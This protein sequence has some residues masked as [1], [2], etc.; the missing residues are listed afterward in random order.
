VVMKVRIIGAGLSGLAAAYYLR[1]SAPN[2][3]IEIIEQNSL[4][5]GR[6]QTFEYARGLVEFGAFMVMPWYKNYRALISDLGISADL[7]NYT[8]FK[9]VYARSQQSDLISTIKFATSLLPS[10][11]SNGLNN[12]SPNPKVWKYRT[13]AEYYQHASAETI[14]GSVNDAVTAYTYPNLNQFAASLYFPFAFNMESTNS[15]NRLARLKSG[16]NFLI[17]TLH[18]YLLENNVAFKFNQ[19]WDGQINNDEKTIVAANLDNS[20]WQSLLGISIDLDYTHFVMALVEIEAEIA[21]PR[22]NWHIF[23]NKNDRSKQLQISAVGNCQ[24]LF[25]SNKPSLLLSIRVEKEYDE[26]EI[27]ALIKSE[28]T[29][30][31]PTCNVKNIVAKH[32]W[33]KCMPI[34]SDDDILNTR[35]A[36]ADKG[37]YLAGDTFHFPCM[38]NAIYT[39]KEAAKLILQK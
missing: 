30:L 37:I 34:S 19:K 27:D 3:E 12:Y 2:L 13:A 28:L 39:G 15:W 7:I 35:K 20:L 26:T 23:Y 16:S 14:M 32:Y 22:E 29:A 9:Q 8:D 18:N 36:A 10:I 31:F 24:Q 11:L 25:S 5:G 38:E 6:L 21:E 17:D 1:K 4:P 33:Q